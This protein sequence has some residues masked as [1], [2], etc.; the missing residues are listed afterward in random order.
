VCVWNEE[1]IIPMNSFA[2]QPCP[3]IIGGVLDHPPTFFFGSCQGI[4]QVSHGLDGDYINLDASE[5]KTNS[6]SLLFSDYI[7]IYSNSTAK[8]WR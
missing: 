5:D 2:C 7:L 6:F 1:E 8:Q 3:P 4:F